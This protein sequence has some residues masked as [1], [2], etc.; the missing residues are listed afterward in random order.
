M[1][2][3]RAHSEDPFEGP[4]QGGPVSTTGPEPEDAAVCMILIHGRGASAESILTLSREF[5]EP[6]VHYVAPQASGH[7]WY[8]NSFLVPREQNQPGLNSGLQRIADLI[9]NL[10]KRGVSKRN[11]LLL[12]F[13]QGACLACEFAARHPV[14]Y[15]G[16]VG[17]SGGLIGAELPTEEYEGSLEGTPVFLGCSDVDMHIPLDRV[18]ATSEVLKSLGGSVET[19]IYPGMGHTVNQDEIDRVKM[20]IQGVRQG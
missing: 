18:H 5:Q 10:E 11:I 15:G 1:T 12:G 13:S 17:L 20:M 14:R 3:F 9:A 6:G 2:L 19:M 4:H 8:P 7:T 16:V